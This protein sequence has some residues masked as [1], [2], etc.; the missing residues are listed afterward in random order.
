MERD[1]VRPAQHAWGWNWGWNP[2]LRGVKIPEWFPV[3]KGWEQVNLE[4][5][6]LTPTPYTLNP[7]P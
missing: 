2:I 6:T 4:P 5:K 3:L 7:R 1:S